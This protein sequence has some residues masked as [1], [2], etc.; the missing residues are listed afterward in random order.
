MLLGVLV[1]GKRLIHLG[2]LYIL[3]CFCLCSF[4]V[5]GM[6]SKLRIAQVT[7]LWARSHRRKINDNLQRFRYLKFAAVLYMSPYSY[8]L[9]SL[10]INAE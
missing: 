4:K 9:Q 5:L 10:N 2:N 1:V 3:Q 8:D 7:Y 6:K